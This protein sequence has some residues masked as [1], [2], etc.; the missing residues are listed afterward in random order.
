MQGEER[1]RKENGPDVRPVYREVAIYDERV[2]NPALQ[3]KGD[4]GHRNSDRL[5]IDSY[6]SRCRTADEE[7][8]GIRLDEPVATVT[9]I[10]KS[11]C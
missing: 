1:R 3:E 4:I 2:A 5:R 10:P 9:N 6:E 11:C 8:G 7:G